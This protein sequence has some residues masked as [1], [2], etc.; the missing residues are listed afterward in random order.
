MRGFTPYI[1]IILCAILTACTPVGVILGAGATAGTAAMEERGIAGAADD[2]R[3][4]TSIQSA[5]IEHD[6]D[7]FRSLSI[8][9]REG[10]V[11]AAGFVATKDAR[12]EAIRRIWKTDGV[13]EVIN[14]IGIDS[15]S[16]G[17]ADAASDTTIAAEIKAKMAFDKDI[18]AVNY[19]VDVIRGVVYLIGIARSEDELNRAIALCRSTDGVKQVKQYMR[20][21]PAAK[22]NGA[23]S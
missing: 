11:L 7:L 13:R 21:K 2:F 14:E 4:N 6:F 23:S 20:I 22:T 18:Y 16:Q 9:V 8:T 12:L 17:L 19:A 3:I 15:N 1:L 10:R 5:L